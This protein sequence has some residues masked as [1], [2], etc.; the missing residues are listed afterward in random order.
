MKVT[1][2]ATLL[3][4]FATSIVPARAD[5]DAAI[6]RGLSIF[7]SVFKE[8]NAFYV[9]SLNPQQ[10][11]ETAI[12]AM[13][14]D[15]DPY[16]EYINAK[17]QED[18]MITA[19]GRYGG[20]GSYIM[21]RVDKGHEGVYISQTYENSPAA[22]V[23][24]RAGDRIVTIDGD[25]ITGWDTEKVSSRL[26]GEPSTHVMLEVCRPWVEDSL[27]RFDVTRQTININPVPYWGVIDGHYGYINLSAFNEHSG[28]AVRDAV[29]ALVADKAVRGIILDLRGNGGGLVESAIQVVGC[30]VPKGTQVLIT[31]GRDKQSERIYKTTT[32]PVAPD[33]PLAILIDGGTASSA[34]ITAGAL[35]DM[36][37]AVVLGSRSYG[38]GLV[39]TTRSL[40]YNGLLK[41]TV[42]KY[43]LP[44]G[45]L[46]QEIDYSRRNLD[47]TYRH[48]PEDSTR[49]YLTA[50]G[51]KVK[52]GAGITPDIEVKYP[53]A[54]RLVYNVVKDHWDF[55]FATRWA[56][57]HDSIAAPE[58]FVVTDEMFEQFKQSIDP[59]RF[60]YDKVCETGLEALRKLAK[61]EGYINDE[62]TAAF[63]ALQAALHH[64]LNH[65][66]DVH[67]DELSQYLAT[68]LMGRYYYN[69]GQV[70]QLAHHDRAVK[71]AI[72]ELAAG[73]PA[74]K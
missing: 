15:I 74:L 23:G 9:D 55:D 2:I 33:M 28:T 31:R 19:T 67:R 38:K 40:P 3:L 17:D 52:G 54:S 39:Q 53:E 64:D 44:S 45:R 51:R 43:Y 29:S 61:A 16:T 65:D 56:A 12:A 60:E 49:V 27:L 8:L 18:F 20:I 68:E 35:Q 6:V 70:A 13:L 50:G 34:E 72:E 58:Q 24:L 63:D 7:N 41:V 32:A 59:E 66:L 25:S 73:T 1:R 37:R 62:T 46:I 26:K 57:T 48:T 42:S 4:L 47:G 36:D 14:N 5:N 22:T 10:S 30:F 71:R 21:Q 69:R 11:I